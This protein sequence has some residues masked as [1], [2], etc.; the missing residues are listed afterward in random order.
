MTWRDFYARRRECDSLGHLV[1]PGNTCPNCQTFVQ[2]VE[3]VATVVLKP[4][5]KGLRARVAKDRGRGGY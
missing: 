2:T 3:S 5:T 4:R 1:I